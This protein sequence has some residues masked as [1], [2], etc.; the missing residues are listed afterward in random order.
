MVIEK[1]LNKSPNIFFI[2]GSEIILRNNSK[3]ILK[4]HLISQGFG[5]K[6]ILSK[7]DFGQIEQVIIENV[8]GSLFGTKTI[9]EINHDQGKVPDQITK[10]FQ[11]PNIGKM[12]NIAIII[13][14]HNE[15][16]NHST[17]WVKQMDECALIVECK[18]L[19]SFEEKI[20]LKH[21]LSFVSDKDKASLVQNIYEMN[22]GNLVAQQNEVQLLKLTYKEGIDLTHKSYLDSAE[23]MPFELEDMIIS[24]NTK[25]ALRI[26]HSIKSTE[27]HYAPLLVWIVGKI[28][29]N[30]SS[31]RQNK[32]PQNSLQK[33][34]VWSNKISD[35][36]AFIKNHSLKKLIQLQKN[37]YELD[38]AS[39]GLSKKDFWNELDNI[40]IDLTTS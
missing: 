32:N 14:S 6:R 35:Y 7:D 11:I 25:H 37:V 3:D 2:Y 1:Y 33:S 4:K 22:A 26:I 9:I 34:G 12:E 18:K 30:A 5:E 23:F 21:E 10:I 31:A 36:M 28:V 15:K 17:K 8:G 24:K 19:K 27:G 13:N 40:V 38:L 20:W 39:K 16:I 29:N